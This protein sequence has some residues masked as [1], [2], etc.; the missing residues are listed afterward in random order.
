MYCPSLTW[1][2]IH[3]RD[4]QYMNNTHKAPASQPCRRD[5]GLGG[6]GLSGLWSAAGI[7][8]RW[9]TP[10]QPGQA[11]LLAELPAGAHYTDNDKPPTTGQSDVP[12]EST[13]LEALFLCVQVPVGLVS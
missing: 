4:E 9:R 5:T 12:E 2:A 7:C 3:A 6:T 10:Q 13:I 1:I 8:D 11:A